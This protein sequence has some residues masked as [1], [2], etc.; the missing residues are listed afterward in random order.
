MNDNKYNVVITQSALDDIDMI[1]M[2]LTH[3]FFSQTIVMKL[4]DRI[5]DGIES[6]G[7][8]PERIKIV[9]FEPAKS[10]GIR[11]LL[12]DKYSV[13]FYLSGKS[14]VVTNVLFGSSDEFQRIQNLTGG[15]LSQN[16]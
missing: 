5:M 6:L 1:M 13:F 15:I 16:A 12:V 3:S 10:K 7:F 9:D 8:M 4:F 11:R 2:Q 14:V